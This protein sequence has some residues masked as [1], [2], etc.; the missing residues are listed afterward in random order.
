MRHLVRLPARRIA[1]AAF[2][3][4]FALGLVP[5]ALADDWAGDRADAV[6]IRALDPVIRT[7][8]AAHSASPGTVAMEGVDPAIRAA[9]AVHATA[10]AEGTAASP[11][12]SP[13]GD[14]FAWGAAALG[15]GAGIAAMCVVLVCVSLLRHGGRLR[16]A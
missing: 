5:T 7:A 9:V 6:A 14:R 1:C 3:V 11:F 15:L 12:V 10:P 16:N 13:A 2:L 8:I 4:T